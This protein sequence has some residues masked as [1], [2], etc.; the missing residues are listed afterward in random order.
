MQQCTLLINIYI[1]IYVCDYACVYI[2][3]PIHR[4]YILEHHVNDPVGSI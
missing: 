3:S 4:H 1:Y 2:R